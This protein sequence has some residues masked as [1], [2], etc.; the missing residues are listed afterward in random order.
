MPAPKRPLRQPL[1]A[2]LVLALGAAL[3]ATAARPQAGPALAAG[4][5]ADAQRLR[6]A[7]LGVVDGAPAASPAGAPVGSPQAQPLFGNWLP[8]GTNAFQAAEATSAPA[9]VSWGGGR[10]D[11]FVRGRSGELYQNF[12]EGR[13][14]NWR[15]PEPFRGIILRSAPSC[16]SWGFE[17]LSCVALIEGDNAVWHFYWDGST[18][19]RQSLGGVATSAPS[20][21]S[22]GRD[23]LAVFVAGERGQLFGRS[24]VRGQWSEWRELGGELRSAPACAAWS[25]DA[26]IHCFVTSRHNS[27][28]RQEVRISQ[29]DITGPGFAEVSMRVQNENFLSLGSAPSATAVAPGRVALLVLNAG[30]ALYTTTWAGNDQGVFWTRNNDPNSPP[31]NSTPACAAISGRIECFARGPDSRMLNGFGD[32]LQSVANTP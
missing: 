11:V 4:S 21:A 17:R 22:P 15:V 6:A 14:F 13:W 12:R 8:M 25:G 27:I 9:A 24:W 5:E 30:Q 16:A 19:A 10:L 26:V 32:L 28:M 20:V 1:L 29:G 31:L 23:L 7:L 2:V 3:L 18:W